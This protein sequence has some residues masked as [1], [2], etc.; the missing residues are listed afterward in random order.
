MLI[1]A[2]VTSISI[3]ISLTLKYLVDVL[4]EYVFYALSDVTFMCV[5]VVLCT[6]AVYKSHS[7]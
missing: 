4:V 5:S 6:S 2:N 7:S 1:D 3:N